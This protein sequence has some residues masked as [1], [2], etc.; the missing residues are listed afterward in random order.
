MSFDNQ[1][2]KLYINDTTNGICFDWP[3]AVVPEKRELYNSTLKKGVSNLKGVF[4]K[5]PPSL[6]SQTTMT[7]P[8]PPTKNPLA[9]PLWYVP[10]V[11]PIQA[12]VHP[13]GCN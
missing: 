12:L 11:K 4:I 6:L 1:D 2:G 8:P 7:P 13:I 10:V 5:V 3:N 9:S